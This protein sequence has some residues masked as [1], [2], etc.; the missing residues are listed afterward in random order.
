MP[1][2]QHAPRVHGRT[3]LIA[4]ALTSILGF[5]P[6][7]LA[8]GLELAF[9]A[10]V[11]AWPMSSQERPGFDNA[12]AE[13][14]ADELGA[15][16]TFV[17]TNFDDVGIR[18][19][20]HSGLCDVAI[21][22]AEGAA[23]VLSTVPYLQ[24]PYVFVTRSDRDLTIA[25]LDDPQLTTLTIGTYQ[26]G[27]PMIALRNRGIEANVREYAA[28][29]RSTG[30]D[31][32]TPILDAVEDGE[33]DVG[34]VYGPHAAARALETDG[35]LTLTAVTPEVDFGSTILQ[36]SRTWTIG[37]RTH[38]DALRDRLNRALAARWDEL[39]AI[40]DA[41]GVPQSPLS[42]PMDTE[43][44]PDATRVGV[45][46]PAA[47][48][49]SLP[50]AAVGE[51]ARRGIAV[52]ENAVSL[53]QDREAPFLVLRAH[54]PTLAAVERA[55]LRLVLVEGV[56][57]LIGGYD[58]EETALL[59]RIAAE[60]DVAFFNV[61][62]E[63]DHLR[64]RTCFPTT[65]HVAPSGRMLAYGMAASLT[66]AT[67]VE[68]F[69]VVQR[70]SAE[71]IASDLAD[72][73]AARGHRLTGHVVVEP[74]AFIYFPAFDQVRAS[75]AD[76]LALLLD[77]DAQ[78]LFLG[79]A[80]S[81]DLGMPILG[82][83]SVRGQSRSYLQ[84]YLQVAPEAGAAPRVVAWDPAVDVPL[85]ETFAARTSEPMEP[86]AWT[87]YA[88][89]RSAFAASDAGVLHDTEALLAYLTDPETAVDVGKAAEARYRAS[90]GQL[91]QE[92]YVVE[93][94]PGAQWGRTALQRTALARVV[95]VLDADATAAPSSVGP[96]D[97][98]SR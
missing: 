69:A 51:D 27:I 72:A 92:L 62:V 56:D 42:R 4:L 20:L 22:V 67:P 47:T 76:A 37:V 96:S 60:H 93:A 71:A 29:I 79:Q 49:A 45:I 89:I 61:G 12:I 26:A 94:V 9:C 6:V 11:G 3:G 91:L 66:D 54:A 86:I 41:F 88:A 38:D 21:G 25:S 23:S 50:N 78:E 24:T 30:A 44:D 32:H 14:L 35:E 53:T 65:L 7:G 68:V 10:P 73:L 80:A 98:T 46:F 8:D 18:D 19:T 13:L 77:A 87:T 31:G 52:A 59:A 5:L 34:I 85:N 64:D 33:V 1:R 2:S 55:A 43:V 75:G 39:V 40:L 17:W 90:D 15:T 70:G 83:S 81:A 16:A 36:L 58:P 28:V 97:C 95:T 48:P 84:R 82:L 74:G 63:D 57:A